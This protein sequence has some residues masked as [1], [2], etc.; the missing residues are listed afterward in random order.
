MLEKMY[1]ISTKGCSLCYNGRL[2]ENSKTVADYSF[3][4]SGEVIIDLLDESSKQEKNTVKI[5]LSFSEYAQASYESIR[6]SSVRSVL[7][8]VMLS[9]EPHYCLLFG[10]LILKPN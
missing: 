4:G 8:T 6:T 7:S 1:K 2:L 10:T 3:G 9:A 5:V